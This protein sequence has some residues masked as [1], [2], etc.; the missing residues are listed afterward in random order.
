MRLEGISLGCY[1]FAGRDSVG[2][3]VGGAGARQRALYSVLANIASAIYAIQEDSFCRDA[4]CRELFLLLTFLGNLFYAMNIIVSPVSLCFAGNVNG[5][6]I[7][8]MVFAVSL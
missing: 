2:A 3:G 7:M 8:A 1:E 4:I 6:R 5:R